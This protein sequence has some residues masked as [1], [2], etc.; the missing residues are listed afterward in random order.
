M[1]AHVAREGCALK[2]EDVREATEPVGP[3]AGDCINSYFAFRGHNGGGR[4]TAGRV[5]AD[6]EP[7]DQRPLAY[8]N[9]WTNALD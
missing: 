2:I 6:D 9:L 5:L 8:Q 7:G 4:G 3:V 1:T